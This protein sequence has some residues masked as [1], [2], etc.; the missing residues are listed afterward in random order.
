M[1]SG[2][3]FKNKIV[4]ENNVVIL[5]LITKAIFTKNI[6]ISKTKNLLIQ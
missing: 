1:V 3:T 5:K 4:I 6:K 2:T